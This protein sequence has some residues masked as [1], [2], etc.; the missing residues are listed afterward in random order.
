M[1]RIRRRLRQALVWVPRQVARRIAER[2]DQAD[3]WTHVLYS[4]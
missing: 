4:R 1:I 2:D 3:L